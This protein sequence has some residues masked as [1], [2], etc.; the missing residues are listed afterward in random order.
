MRHTIKPEGRHHSMPTAMYEFFCGL[1]SLA[2]VESVNS[3]R[4]IPRN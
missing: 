1:E 2:G 3:G 4:F